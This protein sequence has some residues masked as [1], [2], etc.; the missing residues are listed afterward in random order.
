MGRPCRPHP[1]GDLA[2]TLCSALSC[3]IR[4]TIRVA[5]RLLAASRGGLWLLAILGI[6][7]EPLGQIG[8]AEVMVPALW[9]AALPAAYAW[10]QA[11]RL[12]AYVAGSPVRGALIVCGGLGAL[13]FTERDV[14]DCWAGRCTQ[15]SL[16]TM[17]S[18]EH[19][20]SPIETLKRSTTPEARI[21]WEDVHGANEMPRWTALLPV[22]MGRSFIGGLDPNKMIEHAE[23]GLVDQFLRGR[24]LALWTDNELLAYCRRYNVGWIVCRSPEATARFCAW[25]AVRETASMK[26]SGA[27]SLFTVVNLPQNS[28]RR[29]DRDSLGQPSHHLGGCGAR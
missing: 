23:C 18:A 1:G 13:A 19:R 24:P 26:D 12:I 4:Y 16:F 8:T 21:L 29:S 17:D 11:F 9:F 6:S 5:A 15:I 3:L 14:V 28:A 7:W 2:R 27:L 20:I 22:L 10:T 25:K